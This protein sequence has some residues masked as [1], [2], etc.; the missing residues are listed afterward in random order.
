[1]HRTWGRPLPLGKVSVEN[2]KNFCIGTGALGVGTLLLVNPT[3]AALGAGNIGLYYIYTLSKQTTEWNTWIGAIVGAIPPV[4]GW[5]AG[6][7]AS[8][9]SSDPSIL[10]SL[11]F[12]WQFP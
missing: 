10:F 6:K 8:I 3:V 2:A 5:A 11:L 4:M 7:D 9:F 12:L 1:M